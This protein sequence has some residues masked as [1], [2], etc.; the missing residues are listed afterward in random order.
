MVNLSEKAASEIKAIMEQ[1]GGTYQGVRVFVAGGGCSGL[2]YGME[3]CDEPP[4]AED[5]IFEILGV[6]VI[7]DTASYE[8]LK[9]AS[10]DFDDSLGG[11][12]F[13]INNPNAAKSCGCGNSF[14]T[15]EGGE[16]SASGGGCGCGGGGCG[17]H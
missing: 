3:I 10:I 13:K 16:E 8:Y 1:N 11:G 15:A 9:G 7:V 5:Q 4:T 6:K 17:S 14:A 12:G 2:S